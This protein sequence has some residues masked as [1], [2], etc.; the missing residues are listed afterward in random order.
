MTAADP[1]R[2]GTAGFDAR[3]F[4]RSSREESRIRDSLDDVQE[5]RIAALEEI[6]AA[7]WSARIAVR[8]RLRRE[9]RK[10]VRAFSS[11]GDSFYW[12]RG[13]AVTTGWLLSNEGPGR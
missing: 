6:V 8:R 10:Q 4:A 2:R 11:A 1:A 13:E 7:R 12:R 5:Q 9:I 3:A